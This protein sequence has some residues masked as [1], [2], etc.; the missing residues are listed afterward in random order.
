MDYAVNLRSVTKKYTGFTLDNINL[1]IPTGTVM[2]LIGENGA[3]KSTTLRLM[4]GLIRPDSGSV[5][6][7]GKDSAQLDSQIKEQLGVVMDEACFPEGLAA[8]DINKILRSIYKTWDEEKFFSYLKQ[9]SLPEKRMVK[10]YSRG[11]KMKLS[12]AAALSHQTKL[13]ILDEATAGLDPVV[14]D[15]ILE[16]FMTF[17]QDETHT[18]VMSS[19]IVSD[20][21]RVCDYI[22]FLHKGKLVFADEKDV[23]LDRYAILKC[24]LEE[25]LK[26]DQRAVIGRRLSMFG[27]EALVEKRKMPRDCILD[28]AGIEEI[29][30]FYSKEEKA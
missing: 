9:F 20:L 17:M 23:L 26:V 24:P 25:L 1:S 28:K 14:R 10:A 4:L 30:R 13:L 21:E 22:A 8:G 2:G 27:A 16:V 6:L 15:E 18:I 29:M 3:G 11:M 5:T 19:H 7:R 12:I